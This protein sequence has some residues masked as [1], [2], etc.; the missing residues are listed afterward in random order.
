MKELYRTQMNTGNSLHPR[1]YLERNDDDIW[2]VVFVPRHLR[3]SSSCHLTQSRC[4]P[5]CKGIPSIR[6]PGHKPPPPPTT[7]DPHHHP[8][9]HPHGSDGYRLADVPVNIR[10]SERV[11]QKEISQRVRII[12]AENSL[13]QHG[14]VRKKWQR[15]GNL[16]SKRNR[17]IVN[18]PQILVVKLQ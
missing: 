11:F 5:T 9:P 16:W 18:L 14:S 12:H 7:R 15:I 3:N 2:R 6:L 1:R 10:P 4:L 13:P 17:K 8:P